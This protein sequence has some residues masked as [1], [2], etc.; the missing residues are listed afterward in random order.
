[1]K[2][3]PFVQFCV[4]GVMY[5]VNSSPVANIKKGKILILH[6]KL[7]LKDVVLRSIKYRASK[8]LVAICYF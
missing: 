1:M 3:C 6:G 4:V 7:L 8:T 5:S 2:P